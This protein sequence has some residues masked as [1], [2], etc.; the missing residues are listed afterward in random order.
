VTV[1]V[2]TVVLA[3]PDPCVP[4]VRWAARAASRRRAPLRIVVP[5]TGS[6]AQRRTWLRAALTR[7]RRAAPRIVVT[8]VLSDEGDD[9]AARIAAADAAVLV[10]PGGSPAVPGLLRS[11]TCPL[12]VVPAGWA[13]R[14]TGPVLLAV[15][16]STSDTAVA[17]AF[18]EAER[19]GSDLLA[20]HVRHGRSDPLDGLDDRL[21]LAVAA[22]PDVTVRTDV[23]D[24]R[25]EAHL[26][27]LAT[28]ARLLVMGRSARGVLLDRLLPSPT[29]LVAGLARCPVAVV[30][31]EDGP[32]RASLLPE[33]GVRMADLLR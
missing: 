16:P 30:P 8:P 33:H 2:V 13:G 24:E 17:F 21:G 12:V 31:G 19:S 9:R 20:V 32:V 11:V 23:A 26:T 27:R 1:D 10:V 18:A 15:G 7:S 3:P 25:C 4:A 5:A 28:D 29:R 14:D 22:F 6:P